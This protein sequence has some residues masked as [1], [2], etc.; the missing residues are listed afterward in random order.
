MP[1]KEYMND[2]KQN[3]IQ[4]SF[5]VT[6]GRCSIKVTFFDKLAESIE[7]SLRKLLEQKVVI[8]IASAK[9]GTFQGGEVNITNYPAT[10][11]YI[12]FDHK[13]VKELLS[14]D[15][16]PTSETYMSTNTEVLEE[17]MSVA[18]IKKLKEDYIKKKV[19]CNVTVKKVEESLHWYDNVCAKCAKPLLKE[20]GRFKCDKCNRFFTW[21]P[22][23][24]RVCILCFDSTGGI[25]IILGDREVRRLTGK[26]VFDIQLDQAAEDDEDEFPTILQ[27][28]QNKQYQITINITEENVQK[29]SDVYE[30]C[31]VQIDDEKAI[32]QKKE[33]QAISEEAEDDIETVALGTQPEME[34]PG[35]VT[36]AIKTRV[37]KSPDAD[38][39]NSDNIVKNK[40]RAVKIKQEKVIS[41]VK[42]KAR[43]SKKKTDEKLVNLSEVYDLESDDEDET[44]C[45]KSLQEKSKKEK[46]QTL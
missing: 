10:R 39:H 33:M 46:K 44:M 41:K 35:T 28:F 43:K 30:A 38:K 9:I 14:R 6:N 31:H 42:V 29:I 21:P 34:T 18:E 11:F 12:N 24:F 17:F 37:R 36:S 16:T 26:T 32:L 13:A 27:S 20:D 25:P 2:D 40:V 22:R 8:I 23:R 1:L 45:L 7:E 19:V 15:I 4:K 3:K 5:S